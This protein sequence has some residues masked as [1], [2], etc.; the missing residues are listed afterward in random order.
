LDQLKQEEIE[1]S[2]R[3]KREQLELEK[4][5]R[6]Q[7]HQSRLFTL[8]KNK[9]NKEQPKQKSPAKTSKLELAM[10]PQ[11]PA[12]ITHTFDSYRML[13]F[14]AVIIWSDKINLAY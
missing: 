3:L 2:N 6:E 10:D 5:K 9:N 11:R 8:N 12:F 7:Q 13:T 14:L 4:H 1:E